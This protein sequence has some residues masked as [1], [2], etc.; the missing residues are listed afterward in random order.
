MFSSEH[1]I[2]I[3]ICVIFISLLS[4]FSIRFKF[5]LKTAS[6]IMAIIA[7][8]SE[9]FKM[10]THMKYVNGVDISEGMVLLPKSLPFHL[11]SILIFAYFYLPIA[12]DS[13]FKDFILSFVVPIGLVGATLA[14]LM[15]TSGTSFNKP[16]PYQC[17]IYHSAMAWFAIYLI[18]TKQ[19]K[20]GLI[21]WKNNCITLLALT[22]SM[23]WVNSALRQYDTN[24]FFV[25]RPPVEGLPILNLNHGWHVY[26]LTLL[27]LGFIGVSLVHL[28]FMIN[29]RKN[30]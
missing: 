26:F 9:L 13:K 7:L 28:P 15:A 1:F 16:Q 27:I 29:K 4:F 3:A 8:C 5:S 10:F 23:V 18:S 12:K 20:L 6:I 22:I 25:V 21:Q 14:I 11:C 30:K 2:W 24:F 19:A 17:F